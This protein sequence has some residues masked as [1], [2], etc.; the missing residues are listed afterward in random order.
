MA[1]GPMTRTPPL[2]AVLAVQA[3]LDAAGIDS[4]VGGSA[5][6]AS[7][8]LPVEAVHD[9]DVAVDA[10]PD[11]VADALGSLRLPIMRAGD[12][13]SE[14]Y[15]SEELFVLDAGDHTVDV[16]VRFRV[17]A[18]GGVIDIPARPGAVWR[19]LRMARPED[20]AIAYRAMG[21]AERAAALES[22]P[23]R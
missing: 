15:A 7:L 21:N 17:R 8:G 13:D 12:A 11:A 18:A 16:I 10:D 1:G 22:V 6:L 23:P 4:V 3:A 19:G 2:D 14:L 9:W 20:W 5:L